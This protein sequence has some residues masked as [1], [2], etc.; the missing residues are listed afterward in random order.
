[1]EK[2]NRFLRPIS[3]YLDWMVLGFVPAVA[4]AGVVNGRPDYFCGVLGGVG[5]ALA[6]W[7]IL[8]GVNK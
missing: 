5:L 4:I 3:N 8:I 2:L 7:K 1:M 6:G